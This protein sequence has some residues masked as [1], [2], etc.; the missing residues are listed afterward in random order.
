MVDGARCISALSRALAYLGL[1]AG[2]RQP[3]A[4]HRA[5]RAVQ[6]AAAGSGSL[7]EG[8]LDALHVPRRAGARPAPPP[9]IERGHMGY[10]SLRGAHVTHRPE[11]RW[12]AW[13]RRALMAALVIGQTLYA[14]SFML[15]AIPGQGVDALVLALVTVFAIL[16]A[17]IS[18]GFWMAAFG[19]FHRCLGG[20]P[21][22]P[23]RR[24]PPD[25]LAGTALARTAVVMPICHEPVDRCMRGMRAVYR[26][27]AQSG[28]LSHFEFFL[29]SDSRDPDVWLEEQAAWYALC[30]ELGDHGR[31]HYRRRSVHLRHK[32]GNIADFLRR[33]GRRFRYM[34]VLDADS[35]M[36]G[37]TLTR[38]VQ[39]M[40]REPRLGILQSAPRICRA[41]SAFARIQ[42]FS[43]SVYG[44]LFTAGLASV[45]LGDAVY[46]GHNAIIR[47]APFMRHCGLPQLRG[48][49]AFGGPIMSHDFVEAACL[50]R[51]GYEVW[52]EPR[53][54]ASYEESPPTL[55]DELA[56]D[57]RWAKGN[58]QHLWFLL[59]ARRV[60]IA[61]RLALF[62]GV[63][64]YTSSPLWMLFLALTTINVARFTLWP[65][66]YFPQGHRLFPLWPVWHPQ[67]ALELTCTTAFLLLMPKILAFVDIAAGRQARR[68]H[69]GAGKLALGIALESLASAL[70]APIRM[71]AHTRFLLEALCNI[72]VRWAGQNRGEAIPWGKAVRATGGGTLLAAAWAAFAAWLQPLFF[73]WSLPVAVPLVLSAPLTA[74]SSRL[75]PGEALRRRRLLAVPEEQRPVAVLSDL[76]RPLAAHFPP[77]PLSAFDAA[78]IDPRRNALHRQLG[79]PRRKGV[80][81]IALAR[82]CLHEG[83]DALSPHELDRLAQDAEALAW[84]HHRVWRSVDDSP[85]HP[86]MASV[87][88]HVLAD[89]SIPDIGYAASG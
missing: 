76:E 25:E 29:L 69:G 14:T 79:R 23:L 12:A 68:L 44:G 5:L 63:L 31:I 36:D 50:R 53:L 19:F 30:E 2:D 86:T 33:W 64:S 21:W 37:A 48:P 74:W 40:Q 17:W 35:I 4:I 18:T 13:R 3:L 52:L 82:R 87:T 83:R 41:G 84:L 46:W 57:R 70:L 60:P 27:L 85:W 24:H 16:F 65:I 45:Q 42:Q 73:I 34:V 43:S 20:D 26:S 81:T 62:N 51:A 89:T 8:T 10:A 22:S 47:V 66:N 38:M 71:A 49:G 11:W 61:Q 28:H 75:A 1:A 59:C 88:G 54:G 78:V 58:L 72:R 32:S 6:H 80:D 55:L 77:L 7:V 56:R 39:L 9:P 67:W 15:G